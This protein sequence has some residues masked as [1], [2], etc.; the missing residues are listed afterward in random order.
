LN[1]RRDNWDSGWKQSKDNPKFKEQ[2]EWELNAQEQADIISFYFAPNT[3]SPISLLEFGLFARSKKVIVCCSTGF[4]REG[5]VA[6]VCERFGIAFC[7]Q[8]K[9]FVSLVKQSVKEKLSH[10]K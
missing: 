5:N 6:L 2:V 1:P 8:W 9:D 3:K 4:W 10:Q 7:E